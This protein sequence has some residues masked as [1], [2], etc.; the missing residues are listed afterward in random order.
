MSITSTAAS[1]SDDRCVH[2]RDGLLPGCL[3]GSSL[4]D[5][6]MLDI[7]EEFTSPLADWIFI[8]RDI[9]GF[10]LHEYSPN[11]TEMQDFASSP[12]AR[13]FLQE[14]AAAE[15]ANSYD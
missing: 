1:S 8:D 15:F 12:Y 11:D 3:Q 4:H 6:D 10:S 14:L 5:E 7:A 2:F 9:C 13:M